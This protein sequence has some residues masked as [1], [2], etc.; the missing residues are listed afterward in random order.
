LFRIIHMRIILKIL[1]I[2]TISF[3]TTAFLP[4]ISSDDIETLIIVSI[5]LALI[6]GIILTPIIT[7][8]QYPFTILSITL[9][10]LAMNLVL[11]KLAD[12][13]VDGFQV[14]GWLPVFILS[15]LIAAVSVLID[16]YPFRR[17]SFN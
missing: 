14:D 2:A 8:L 16:N 5:T 17:N 7:A 4:G 13:F 15:L 11:V 3:L 9:F 1:A 6:N 12:H 10:V